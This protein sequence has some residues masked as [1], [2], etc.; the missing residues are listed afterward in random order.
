MKRADLDSLC[1]PKCRGAITPRLTK[2]QGDE[3]IE[4]TLHCASCQVD[5]S[6]ANGIAKM[7]PPGHTLH[8]GHGGFDDWP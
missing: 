1:C 2:E 6:I 5:Y 7:L 4:G 8:A 3:V